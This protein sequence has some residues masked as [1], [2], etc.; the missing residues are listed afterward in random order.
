[1]MCCFAYSLR[2]YGFA[3]RAV[4]S[5]GASLILLRL[6]AVGEYG[7]AAGLLARLSRKFLRLYALNTPGL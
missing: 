5:Y 1:M 7:F 3:F 4:A 6:F 2:E